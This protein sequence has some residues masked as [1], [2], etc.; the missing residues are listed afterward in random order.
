[1]PGQLHARKPACAQALVE[2]RQR[3]VMQVG[4]EAMRGPG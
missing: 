4:H 3:E 1:M 2:L